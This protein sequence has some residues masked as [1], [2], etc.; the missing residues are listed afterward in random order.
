MS[1]TWV[2]ILGL[3]ALTALIRAS[4]PVLLGGRELP[5][6]LMRMIALL[7]PALLAALI[8]IGTFT[9]ADGDLVLDARAAGLGAAGL[10]L[11]RTHTMLA[12][13]AGAAV[14]AALVRA[15]A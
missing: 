11:L 12:A 1:D 10:I 6:L 8:V 3:A 4:G 9:D 14:A 13:C 15:I 5:S 7:A 2:T